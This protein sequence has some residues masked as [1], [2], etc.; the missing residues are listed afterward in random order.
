MSRCPA[1][2]QDLTCCAEGK[3]VLGG[4]V[5]FPSV[6]ASRIC[7]RDS[8]LKQKTVYTLQANFVP[9]NVGT[10]VASPSLPHPAH[11]C[12]AAALPP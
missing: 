12:P 4:A 10:L 11:A 8:G 3:V 5:S 6:V 2:V 7:L 9:V 1:V